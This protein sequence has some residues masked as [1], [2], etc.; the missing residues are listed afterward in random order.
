MCKQFSAFKLVGIMNKK[1][2]SIYSL[3]KI[4]KIPKM[5]VYDLVVGNTKNPRINTLYKIAEGLG[6]DISEIL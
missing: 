4:S 5:T 2:I 1:G 3:S 6:V